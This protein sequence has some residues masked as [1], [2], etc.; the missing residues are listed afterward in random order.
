MEAQMKG[1]RLALTARQRDVLAAVLDLT[2]DGRGPSHLELC[3]KVGIASMNAIQRHLQLLAEGGYLEHKFGVARSV[4][5]LPRG[6]LA[7]MGRE[8][9]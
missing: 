8:A 6:R 9:A 5:V 2:K 7:L 4:R 3:N 1:K